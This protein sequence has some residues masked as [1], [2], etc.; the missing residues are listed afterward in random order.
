MLSVFTGPNGDCTPKNTLFIS[1]ETL[2]QQY[3][4][5]RKFKNNEGKNNSL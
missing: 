4:P 3:F 2:T 5:S 1:N